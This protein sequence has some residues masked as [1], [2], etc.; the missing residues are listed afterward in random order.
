MQPPNQAPRVRWAADPRTQE[1]GKGLDAPADATFSNRR[2]RPRLP[3]LLPPGSPRRR[4]GKEPAD[5]DQQ[6]SADVDTWSDNIEA[7]SSPAASSLPSP[8]TLL[9]RKISHLNLS[10][11]SSHDGNATGPSTLNSPVFAAVGARTRDSDA[12]APAKSRTSS[13]MD[14]LRR[15]LSKRTLSSHGG[16]STQPSSRSKKRFELP[17]ETKAEVKATIR[18]AYLKSFD[19]RLDLRF[20]DWLIN[21]RERPKG[22]RDIARDLWVASRTVAAARV[23]SKN[24]GTLAQLDD[25]LESQDKLDVELAA[26][27][28][29]AKDTVQRHLAYKTSN[30]GRDAIEAFIDGARRQGNPDVVIAN[31]L[32]TSDWA[33]QYANQSQKDARKAQD[34]AAQL[35]AQQ[36]DFVAALDGSRAKGPRDPYALPS[37]DESGEEGVPAAEP[38]TDA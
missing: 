20:D 26:T 33:S 6:L 28:K 3:S 32:L 22:D 23:E 38:W 7:P 9:R 19:Q 11:A 12:S 37:S 15:K 4:S 24:N 13:P 30:E 21:Q 16:D 17:P 34:A 31:E 36:A 27:L 25:W 14:F 35:A 10:S 8:N 18:K 5:V 29:Q 2:T 1:F